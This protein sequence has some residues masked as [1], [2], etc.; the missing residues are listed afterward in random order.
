MLMLS[1]V[2]FQT[3][4]LSARHASDKSIYR[5]TQPPQSTLVTEIIAFWAGAVLILFHSFSYS[6]AYFGNNIGFPANRGAF[7]LPIKLLFRGY[8]Y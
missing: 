8:L 6:G 5:L 7:S 4:F 3:M 1:N 2:I